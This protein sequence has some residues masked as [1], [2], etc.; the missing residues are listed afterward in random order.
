MAMVSPYRVVLADQERRVLVKRARSERAAHRDVLRA[1]VILAAAE[2]ASNAEIARRLGVC[3]DTVRKWRARFCACGLPGLADRPRPGRQRT[4]P[5][6]AEVEVK[7]LACELPTE[8]EVPLARWSYTELAAEAVSRGV[9]ES[10][11]ASTVGRW[12][13][14]DA[15]RPWQYR[16][17]IFPRDPDFAVKAGRALDLYDRLWE[18][19]P[20]GADEYVISADE[21]SQLQAL[22]RRHP[23]LPPAPERIRRQEF[24]YRRGGTLAYLAA[25]DVHAAQVIGR[26]APTTGIEPFGQLVEQVMTT[27]PYASARRVFWVVDNGSSHNGI[28]SIDRMHAAWPTA[29]L[30]HLP[31][32]AS[33]LNQVEIFFSI[34]QR[35]VIKPGDFAD[36]DALAERLLAFQD[37]YNATA[38]PFDWHFGRK[39][40]N[41]LLERLT[42]HEPLAA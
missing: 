30:V 15:I 36:L 34:V 13:R 38:E 20:L 12:L 37:R 40:L 24:E 4:F 1:Q 31:I 17:W 26:T 32:H 16:S 9:V 3:D 35:K 33:W 27:E 22:R 14:A 28:R 10:I 18:G 39:S 5:K 7:A 42:A 19:Q 11:S 2:G 8:S 21:K 25:Y 29:E 41:R 23:D 6:T